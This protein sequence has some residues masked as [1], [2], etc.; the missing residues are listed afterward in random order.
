MRSSQNATASLEGFARH[1]KNTKCVVIDYGI[2]NT[3]SVMQALE[4]LGA[5]AELTSNFDTIL[6]ADRVIL[7]GVGAFGRAIAR[8]RNIGLEEV[9]LEYVSTGRPFMGICVGMQLLMERGYEFGE[10]QGLGLLQGAV[11]KIDFGSLD[12]TKER[13]PIIGWNH[14]HTNPNNASQERLFV[15]DDQK[16]S[17]YFVHSFEV[18]PENQEHIAAWSTVGQNEL[19]AA[20]AHD[21]IFGVQFHPERSSY[22]G[23]RFLEKFLSI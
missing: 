23:L 2:G 12:E 11:E 15:S 8:L 14:I 20:V 10:H 7:P 3:F 6:A 5:N 13:V 22:F 16:A 9:L 4:K 21:N 19:V 1:M 18:K 17:Y